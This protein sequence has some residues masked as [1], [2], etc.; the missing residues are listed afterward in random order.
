M[1]R[2]MV[3]KG[4]SQDQVFE[5][6]LE[7]E[8]LGVE[9]SAKKIRDHLGSGS[10]TTISK[11]FKQWQV[12]RPTTTVEEELD[13]KIILKDIDREIIADF[14][15]N[16]HPQIIALI[17]SY[18]EPKQAANILKV[19]PENLK[20]D[21][22]DRMEHLGPVQKHFVQKIAGVIR[23]ELKSL[24][25]HLGEQKGGMSFVKKVREEMKR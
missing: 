25:N 21:V 3:N 23:D 4:L 14:F 7:I 17:F 22:L 19:F 9:P 1:E 11:Y 16:E 18:L 8:R 2:N 10:L 5:A 6:A 12:K 15:S 24:D 13:L 20:D